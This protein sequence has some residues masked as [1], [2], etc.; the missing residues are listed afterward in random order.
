MSDKEVHLM[1]NKLY[2]AVKNFAEIKPIRFCMPGHNGE[3]IGISTDL[4]ITE[5]SF[6]DNLLEA[7]GAIANA[8]ANIAKAYGVKHAT[9]L[10]CG[11][12]CG[13]AMALMCAKNKGDRLLILGDAHK[14]VHNYAV[15]FGFDI[16]AKRS[17]DS[18]DPNDYDAIVITSPNY[19]G[20]TE[21]ISHLNGSSAL[22]ICDAS[23]G[24]HFAFCS[25]L[26]DLQTDVADITILSLH[27]TLPVLTGGAAVITNDR[28]L[29][30][31][32][33]YARS[34][35]HSTS[36]SY[37][38]MTSIDNAI[39]KMAAEGERMYDECLAAITQ[40]TNALPTPYHVQTNNDPTRLC[41]STGG[42]DAAIVARQLELQK[43]YMEMTYF[44]T[45]VAIV[46]PYNFKHLPKLLTAL[47][48]IDVSAKTNGVLPKK[49]SKIG[50]KSRKVTFCDLAS[51]VGKV[52]AASIGI[53]PP[54]V[55]VLT[56]GDLIDGEMVQFL[57]DDKYQLFG[58]IDG[59]VPVYEEN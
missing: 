36:P 19:F 5:L 10:T 21:N 37:L 22:I 20:V 50:V 42:G 38:T 11:A 33:C 1:Q 14:S 4:D 48:S 57:A 53:Y 26:P 35:L 56:N 28:D 39:C 13:V 46:T 23:H 52:C 31:M 45:L 17:C 25:K 32:L 47:K 8:E 43:I 24:A 12:T 34:I 59:K 15:L 18:F 54:G 51:S 9:M 16:T 44:D 49:P 3:D 30:N 29:H 6:S 41:I 58:L 55:P 40:F 2:K 7:D 27:K